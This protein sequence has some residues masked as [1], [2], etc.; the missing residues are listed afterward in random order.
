MFSM[1]VTHT[2]GYKIKSVKEIT[3]KD[4]ITMCKLLSSR[5]E[6]CNLCEFRPYGNSEGGGIKYVFK[7]GFNEIWN[8]TVML[9]SVSKRRKWPLVNENVMT[10][11]IDDDEIIYN[12]NRRILFFLKSFNEAPF[13]TIEELKIWEECFEQI[14]I[15]RVGN[16]PRERSLIS[17]LF[18][19]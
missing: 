13:F 9:F 14:G 1:P 3:K 17:K 19:F 6:Y 18:D 11:W 15:I 2:D 8:K 5:K 16:Y 4:I 7:E 10:E 12:T